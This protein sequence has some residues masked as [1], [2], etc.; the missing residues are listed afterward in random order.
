MT[1]NTDIVKKLEDMFHID[2]TIKGE[3]GEYQ[4]WRKIHDDGEKNHKKALKDVK[5]KTTGLGY[6][7]IKEEFAKYIARFDENKSLKELDP[8]KKD[9]YMGKAH[10]YLEEFAKS[11]KMDL[12]DLLSQLNQTGINV[13]LE[14]YRSNK[15]AEHEDSLTTHYVNTIDPIKN[16][17]KIFESLKKGKSPILDNAN[18]SKIKGSMSHY[19]EKHLTN[20][21]QNSKKMYSN[22][23]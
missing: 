20:K 19:L 18:E 1:D 4:P 15:I 22:I 13:I 23:S 2:Y 7:D 9:I 8:V 11:Q 12:D 6:E 5:E 10:K 14:S 21:Y 16:V 3:D 17:D